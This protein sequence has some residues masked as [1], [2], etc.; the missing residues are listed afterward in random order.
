MRMNNPDPA[1]LRWEDRF[2]RLGLAIDLTMVTLVIINLSWIIFD[3]LFAFGGVQS[4]LA[5]VFS[6]GFVD[7][8]DTRIHEWFFAYDLC[9]VAIFV[10]ELLA[11][12]IY[13]I[14][15]RLYSHWA[16][17][18]FIHWYDVLGCIPVGSLRALRILRVIAVL[19]RLQ[20]LGVIDYTQWSLYQLFNRWYNIA[21]EE[22]SDR[23]AVKI[24]E[25]VQIE[26]KQG[27]EL[28]RKVIERVVLPRKQQLIDSV[29]DNLAGSAR[30]LYSDSQADLETYI[31]DM[32]GTALHNNLEIRTVEKIPML[33]AAISKLLEHAVTDIVCN[34]LENGVNNMGRPEFK[35]IVTDITDAI[36]DGLAAPE[37]E[38]SGTITDALADLVEVVKDEIR[39]QRWKEALPTP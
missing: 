26:L 19:T 38:S 7:W 37:S 28:E 16:A 11:R 8:Y 24:L 23:I 18:P 3:S 17:Y 9:F 27:R 30:E 33:G 29:T 25:G 32:V 5:L 1:V 36:I 20:K 6:Q 31:K 12:W 15:H 4:L 2:P 35:R 10:T 22:L 13:A 34:S 39:I 21:L 14:R